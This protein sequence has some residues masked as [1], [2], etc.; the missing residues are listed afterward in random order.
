VPELTTNRAVEDAAIAW[1]MELERSAGREPRDVR[2]TRSPVDIDS[3][4]RRIEVKAVG[5]SAR[6]GDLPLELPQ[7]AA[8]RDDPG[9]YLYVVD[10]L[11]QGDPAHFQLRV[12]GGEHLQ[13]LLARVKEQRYY[14]LPWP[15][16]DYDSCPVGLAD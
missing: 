11:R 5:R 7:Y 4:P 1:V 8:A 13:R 15:C 9:F 14:A 12:L 10:N 6:G 3:P 16:A 2:Y